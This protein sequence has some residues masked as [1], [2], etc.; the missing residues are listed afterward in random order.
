MKQ[1]KNPSF[2]L[3]GA[4][5]QLQTTTMI[6]NANNYFFIFLKSLNCNEHN[7]L[8]FPI[9]QCGFKIIRKRKFLFLV[10]AVRLRKLIT[11]LQEYSTLDSCTMFLHKNRSIHINARNLLTSSHV[12]SGMVARY[13][14]ILFTVLLNFPYCPPL[15]SRR[16]RRKVNSDVR[17]PVKRPPA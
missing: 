2:G 13:T 3:V 12:T 6:S 17:R 14:P 8:A 15:Q 7:L 10:C 5:R 4:A 9:W 1:D 11:N 16:T